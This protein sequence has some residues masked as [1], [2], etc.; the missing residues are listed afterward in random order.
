LGVIPAFGKRIPSVFRPSG[1]ST[2]ATFVPELQ[3][4]EGLTAGTQ[5]RQGS[6]MQTFAFEA[7]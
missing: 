5:C 2:Q 7:L 1:Q 6:G 4:V 3:K